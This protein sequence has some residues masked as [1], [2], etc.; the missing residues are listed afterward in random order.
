MPDRKRKEVIAEIELRA[1]REEERRLTER[2]EVEIERQARLM[3]VQLQFAATLPAD[4]DALR[5]LL[6][7]GACVSKPERPTNGN[8]HDQAYQPIPET[9]SSNDQA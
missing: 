8:G 4:L 9:M 7:S 5:G 6:R 2:E 3:E 1:E